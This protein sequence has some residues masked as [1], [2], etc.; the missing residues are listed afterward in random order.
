[1][2]VGAQPVAGA[3]AEPGRDLTSVTAPRPRKRRRSG[4][5]DA[6][7]VG[8]GGS[9]VVDVVPASGSARRKRSEVAGGSAR[10]R[11]DGAP[12]RKRAERPRK[13][14]D[15]SHM[16]AVGGV[17][18][19][20]TAS[21]ATTAT[22]TR[23]S[24]S[25]RSLVVPI[26]SETKAMPIRATAGVTSKRARSAPAPAVA[27]LSSV[28]GRVAAPARVHPPG[29]GGA[30]LPA[31]AVFCPAGM[32]LDEKNV[33]VRDRCMRC[34]ISAK[35]TPMMRKGPDGCRSMCNACGLRWARHGVF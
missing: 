19:T 3:M 20:V 25:I 6:S 26:D 16:A 31:A 35:N 30:Q 24:T 21:A 11:V 28:G 17:T 8:G 4:A 23:P 12:A 22:G 18:P 5:D 33:P 32:T 2:A 10:K 34:S 1:V 13:R 15:V 29:P 9:S 7:T 14:S 27:A